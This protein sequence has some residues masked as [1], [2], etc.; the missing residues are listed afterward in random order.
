LAEVSLI[1]FSTWSSDWLGSEIFS[2]CGFVCIGN[3]LV[4]KIIFSQNLVEHDLDVVAG[5]PVAVVIK[6]AGHA[7]LVMLKRRERHA[8]AMRIV[9]QSFRHAWS[10]EKICEMKSVLQ[11]SFPSPLAARPAAVVLVL[12]HRRRVA[13]LGDGPLPHRLTI[14]TA[15]ARRHH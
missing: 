14:Q 8:P 2:R 15:R 13:A 1:D 3:L 12:L 7:W 4:L 11:S 6:A 10:L 9:L 5:V